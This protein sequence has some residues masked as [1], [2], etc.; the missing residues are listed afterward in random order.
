MVCEAVV[1]L[2][3]AE[4]LLEKTGGDAV[5]EV[6]RN[7]EAYTGSVDRPRGPQSTAFQGDPVDGGTYLTPEGEHNA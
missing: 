6:I 5:S 3:L 2:V 1:A 7:L 4:A